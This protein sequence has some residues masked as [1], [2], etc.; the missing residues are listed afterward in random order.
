M[1]AELETLRQKVQELQRKSDDDERYISELE[2]YA[3]SLENNN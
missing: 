3:T 1:V 2:D